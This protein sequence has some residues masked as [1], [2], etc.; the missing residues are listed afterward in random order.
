MDLAERPEQVKTR[1]SS[2]LVRF[3]AIVSVAGALSACQET[4]PLSTSG[5][6]VR[7]IPAATLALMREKGTDSH[8]PVLIRTY[9]K[10]AE[11]EIW[12]MKADGRY[13]LLKTFPMC[14]WSG[15]L[16]PK[17]KEG[18]R[19]VPEGFYT[20]TPG[21]MNP[22]SN[23]YLSFNVG[24]PNAYDKA[25]GYTGGLI[26]VHGACSSAGCFSMTD[27][28]I[29]EIYA[30]AREA[31]AGGQKGIQMQSMPFRMTPENLAQHRLDPN[32]PFWKEIKKGLDAFEVTQQEPQVAFC[33]RRYVF[34]ATPV[35]AS[36]RMDAAAPCPAL[37]EDEQLQLEIAKKDQDD[38]AKV[39]QLVAR[40]VQPIRL[41]YSDG[42]QH[43]DFQ[44]VSLVSRPEALQSGPIEIPLDANGKPLSPLIK[45][46]EAKQTTVVTPKP[47]LLPPAPKLDDK[48]TQ[49]DTTIVAASPGAGQA[50]SK[51]FYSGFLTGLSSIGEL[52][53]PNSL[54][55]GS[56]AGV[57]QPNQV[58][59]PPSRSEPAGKKPVAD[60]G[61]PEATK[62]RSAL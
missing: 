59:L 38:Q 37:Q 17:I 29:A 34:N 35:N 58:P 4:L 40:G 44:N 41:L 30:I 43:P 20:I 11:L 9:K 42:G 49:P 23:Y 27:E 24:Y 33:G 7:P 5:R 15:Q 62:L 51:P 56:S 19:Q 10:E 55:G 3:A 22:N 16:G 50:E 28:Q 39:A 21:Q 14:R 26:M 31:F 47:S 18:D 52:V 36:A 1:Q 25:H 48:A 61:S 32:M 6:A 12:K 45:A 2:R 46:A 53:T 13:T 60:K 57:S 54:F 8:A